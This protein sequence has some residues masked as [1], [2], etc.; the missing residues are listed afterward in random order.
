MV[1]FALCSIHGK[2]M[3]GGGVESTVGR[4][5]D[6]SVGLSSLSAMVMMSPDDGIWTV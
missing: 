6:V 5:V 1:T 3:I 4:F 2:V